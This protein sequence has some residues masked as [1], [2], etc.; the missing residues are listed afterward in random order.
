MGNLYDAAWG[1]RAGFRDAQERLR[2]FLEGFNGLVPRL[3][4]QVK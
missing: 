4:V 1:G 2:W 3:G